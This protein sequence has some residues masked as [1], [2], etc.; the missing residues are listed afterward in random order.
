MLIARGHAVADD[1][2]ILKVLRRH[3]VSF[4]IVGGHAVN[5]H[6]YIRATEDVDV[7]WQRSE[8]AEQRLLA[9]LT[10]LC[11]EYFGDDID[12]ITGIERT[13]AV[14]LPHIRSSHMMILVTRL[15]FLDLFDHVPGLPQED[16]DKFIASSVESNG[17]HY[18]S[19]DWL[20][21][22]KRAAGRTKDR[23]DLEELGE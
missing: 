1:I 3:G 18:V 13:H 12:P 5:F 22:M 16:L 9:A 8:E 19:I 11:A 2:E 17:L 4:V 14:S 10:E 20:R 15:G 6:G 7:V 23:L 21:K